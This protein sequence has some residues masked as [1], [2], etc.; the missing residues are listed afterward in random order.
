MV[1]FLVITIIIVRGDGR[2][3][4]CSGALA[5]KIRSSFELCQINCNKTLE[6]P[7]TFLLCIISELYLLRTALEALCCVCR[8]SVSVFV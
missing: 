1:I 6:I 7:A 2:L 3:G 5:L 8:Y 4:H